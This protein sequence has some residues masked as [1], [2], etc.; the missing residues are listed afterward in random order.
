MSEKIREQLNLGSLSHGDDMET[1]HMFFLHPE[2]CEMEKVVKY[3]PPVS[4]DYGDTWIPHRLPD[5]K[6]LVDLK[7][8]SAGTGKWPE[9][10]SREKG[11]LIHKAIVANIIELIEDLS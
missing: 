10:A 6:E 9:H 5:G 1:S 3:V 11:D 4:K 2:L 8:K 7:E